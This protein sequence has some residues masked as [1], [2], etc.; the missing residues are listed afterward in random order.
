MSTGGGRG[1]RARHAL[2]FRRAGALAHDEGADSKAY[3]MAA[4]SYDRTRRVT[5]GE[6][7]EFVAKTPT[8]EAIYDRES[9]TLRIG[10]RGTDSLHDIATDTYITPGKLAATSR[11]RKDKKF[12]EDAIARYPGATVEVSGHSLGGAIA[13]QLKRDVPGVTSARTF[14]QAVAPQD[15][16]GSKANEGIQRTYMQN[17]PLYAF[18]GGMLAQGNR[19]LQGNTGHSLKGMRE[20][21]NTDFD[22][23]SLEAAQNNALKGA[24]KGLANVADAVA[25]TGIPGLR[26]YAEKASNKLWRNYYEDDAAPDLPSLTGGG[27]RNQFTDPESFTRE[28]ALPAAAYITRFPPLRALNTANKLAAQ[29]Q[30]QQ[31]ARG[32]NARLTAL[33]SQFV[34]PDSFLRSK[35]LPTTARYSAQYAGPAAAYLNTRGPRGQKAARGVTAFAKG[36]DTLNR[37]NNAATK[38][39]RGDMAGAAREASHVVPG[40]SGQALGT[41]ANVQDTVNTVTRAVDPGG[42]GMSDLAGKISNEFT[43]GDSVLAQTFDPRKNG[44]ARLFGGSSRAEKYFNRA[45]DYMSPPPGEVTTDMG[46]DRY[47]EFRDV[48]PKRGRGQ[49]DSMRKRGAAIRA[50]MDEEGI[51]M[52]EASKKLKGR[53]F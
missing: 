7:Y 17:D 21:L 3:E 13:S 22:P 40:A 29:H 42:N 11:Y 23:N 39:Q 31:R 49:S 15:L 53:K 43:N 50:L 14:N 44:M 38:Y 8:A 35:A 1:P 20:H 47:R 5:G 37:V 26:G 6:Q 16:I 19:V 10:I 33:R 27:M 45:L 2:K 25:S 12:T 9:N 24:S 41:Y 36:V 52:I 32:G 51:S 46:M 34:D 18:T 4:R 30:R 28:T 48:M